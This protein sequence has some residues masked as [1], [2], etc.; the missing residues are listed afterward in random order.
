MSPPTVLPATKVL[1]THHLSLLLLEALALL[2]M[3]LQQSSTS[4]AVPPSST[5]LP[6][7]SASSSV[8]VT[9]VAVTHVAVMVVQ[10][11]MTLAISTGVVASSY[12]QWNAATGHMHSHSSHSRHMLVPSLLDTA[13]ARRSA[14]A[15]RDLLLTVAPQ[16][17]DVIA[18]TV[19]QL[20][21]PSTTT[22]TNANSIGAAAKAELKYYL[23]RTS[24]N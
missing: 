15:R 24:N 18:F 21:F 13:A 5:V 6:L 10:I 8:A 20:D 14:A 1:K 7:V 19:A 22:T 2:P 3:L 4:S 9:H 12:D 16:A 17:L 23:I 11:L